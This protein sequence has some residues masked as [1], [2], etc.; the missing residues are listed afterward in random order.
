MGED[1]SYLHI[2]FKEKGH[3]YTLQQSK[4][5]WSINFEHDTPDIFFKIELDIVKQEKETNT[6][7]LKK[8]LSVKDANIL[9]VQIRF[10]SA[11]WAPS[12]SKEV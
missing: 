7:A 4:R 8:Y 9:L 1:C 12:I 6:T 3:H 10:S 11:T 2:I 5:L